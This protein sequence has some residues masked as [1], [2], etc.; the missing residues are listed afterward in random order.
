MYLYVDPVISLEFAS[1]VR[2]YLSN[3]PLLLLLAKKV[4]T[5]LAVISELLLEN[6]LAVLPFFSFFL[7]VG[8]NSSLH[9]LLLL[10]GT[11]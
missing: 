7:Y 1:K 9:H 5:V 6:V 2:L 3:F 4:N 11:A 8:N 10:G